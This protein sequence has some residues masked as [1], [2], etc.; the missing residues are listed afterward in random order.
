MI[1]ATDAPSL[2]HEYYADPSTMIFIKHN[3][4]MMMILNEQLLM[5]SDDESSWYLQELY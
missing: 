3:T 1:S 5:H 4:M 2:W